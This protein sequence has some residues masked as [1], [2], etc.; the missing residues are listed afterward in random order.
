M[1]LKV[2]PAMGLELLSERLALAERPAELL[3][4]LQ[5]ASL[6]E[7]RRLPGLLSAW[8]LLVG[9]QRQAVEAWLAEPRAAL[10][11]ALLSEW[12]AMVL[13]S[14]QRSLAGPQQEALAVRPLELPAAL[15]WVSLLESRPRRA[16]PEA[17]Q[18]LAALQPRS[19]QR[20]LRPEGLPL[21]LAL[22]VRQAPPLLWVRLPVPRVQARVNRTPSGMEPVPTRLAPCL[23][24]LPRQSLRAEHAPRPAL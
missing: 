23:G 7:W 6:W 11:L 5:R 16:L 4:A 9:S 19:A 21:E 18:S 20:E 3:V 2:R 12:R 24:G 17:R 22:P 8:R 10:Q 1:A 13:P 15:R 14:A